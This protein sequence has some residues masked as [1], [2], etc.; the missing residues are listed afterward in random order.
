MDFAYQVKRCYSRPAKKA[1]A[2]ECL[3]HLRKSLKG[4]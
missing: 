2:T 1:M 4:I 3:E